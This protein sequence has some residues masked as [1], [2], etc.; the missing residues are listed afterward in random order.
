MIVRLRVGMGEEV[1]SL[2]E[3][4]RLEA[5]NSNPA[6][7]ARPRTSISSSASLGVARQVLRETSSAKIVALLE[8]K[9]QASTL[10]TQDSGL[11]TQDSRLRTSKR[12]RLIQGCG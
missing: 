2:E 9:P 5:G 1:L 4:L 8:T 6:T 7:R 11:K 3:I 12:K 10:K